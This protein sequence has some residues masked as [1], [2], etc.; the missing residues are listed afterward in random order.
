MGV[1]SRFRQYGYIEWENNYQA[2]LVT[3]IPNPAVPIETILEVNEMSLELEEATI[4]LVKELHE[5]INT[6]DD[7]E[8]DDE[9]ENSSDEEDIVVE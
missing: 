8:T 9:S 4:D 7:K 3:V 2:L 1:V 6:E 5:D